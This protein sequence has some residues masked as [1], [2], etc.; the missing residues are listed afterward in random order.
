MSSD[1][2]PAAG[3]PAA[4]VAVLG[5]LLALAV[6]AGWV[7]HRVRAR[8]Q[9][10]A[11]LVAAATQGLVN[12]TTIDHQQVDTDVARILDSSTGAFRDDFERRAQSFAD[13]ARTARSV[14]VGTVT[15]AGVQSVEADSGR[16]L[17]AMTVMTSNAGVP[18]R[19]PRAWRTV[20]TV[21]DTDAGMK[22]SAVE[23]VP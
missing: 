11:D 12:L 16:V 9:F 5:A 18:E 22:V 10:S 17:V 6:V 13:A 20:V 1:E 8:E 23:F 15:E 14:S 3:R 7:D 21:T 2:A 19:A 4:V